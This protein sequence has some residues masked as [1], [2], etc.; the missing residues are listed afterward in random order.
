MA[1]FKYLRVL[2][3][4]KGKM[5]RENNRRSCAM[6]AVAVF[7][8]YHCTEEGD[9]KGEALSSPVDL[10]SSTQLWFWSLGSGQMN[11]M[12]GPSR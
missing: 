4:S 7:L 6:S 10:F 3:I 5:V 1:Q 12:V 2:F 11:K 9:P 8:D